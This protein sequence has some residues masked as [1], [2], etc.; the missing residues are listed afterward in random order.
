MLTMLIVDDE[1]LVR[2]GLTESIDWSEYNIEIVGEASDGD[3]GLELALK[4]KPDIILTDI[5]MPTMDGLELMTKIRENSLESSII[6]LS[7]YDEFE[8]A[9][10]AMQHGAESYLLKP[11]E[12]E[13]LIKTVLNVARKAKEKIS[14]RQYYE[15]LKSE[16]TSI[17]RQ[18]L[19]DLI[20]GNIMGKKEIIEKITFLDLPMDIENNF[21]IVIRIDHY[22]SIVQKCSKEQLNFFKEAIVRQ[23]SHG[24]LLNDQYMGVFIE[25]FPGEW[26]VVMHIRNIHEGIIEFVKEQNME[27]IRRL[28]DEFSYSVLIGISSLCEDIANINQAYKEACTACGNKLLTGC[29][30][31]AYAKDLD[32]V[33]CRREIKSA[34]KY[35]KDNY[36]K[37]ITVDMAAKDL[38]ISASSLMHLFK[39]ELGK[40]FYDC[41]TEY[42]IEMA[43]ELLKESGYKIY[44]ISEKVG[45]ND[46]KYFSQVFKKVTGISPSE[47]IKTRS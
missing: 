11:I 10:E 37:N 14:T 5:R 16:L 19:Q 30:S 4:Y 39:N 41:L 26:V 9:R 1:Y 23:I 31:V 36:R 15:K 38:F 29:S 42:R 46:E 40:T 17:K 21:I 32:V 6:V 12:N 13:I 34:V 43:K 27:L 24:L 33:G 20:L 35:I 2:F 28:K 22:E 8:Y 47:Y 3:E 18:F 44:E 45:F 25:S 7:G